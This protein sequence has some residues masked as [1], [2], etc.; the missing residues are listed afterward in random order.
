MNLIS[1]LSII[2]PIICI[3]VMTRKKLWPE[4]ILNSVLL[5]MFVYGGSSPT[6]QGVSKDREGL[7]TDNSDRPRR[8]INKRLQPN[9]AKFLWCFFGLESSYLVWGVLQEKIMTTRY[10][11]TATPFNLTNHQYLLSETSNINMEFVTHGVHSKN[12]LTVEFHDSQFLVFLNRITAFIVSIV[13]LVH[14]RPKKRRIFTHTDLDHGVSKPMAPLYEYIYSS[15][16][17]ILSS[18]CQYEAL[19]YVNFPTQV[20]SKSCKIIP[21][22]LMSSF[23]MKKRH[24]KVDYMNAFILSFGMFVF[25]LYQPANKNHEI[26][27]DQSHQGSSQQIKSNL[28]S[29]DSRH[30]ISELGSR[31]KE[32]PQFSGLIILTL[33]LAFDSFTSNWQQSLFSRYGVNEWQMMAATNFYS[34]LLTLTSLYQLG[35]LTPALKLLA[36]SRTLLVDCVT[37]S[38]MSSIGQL[39]VFYTIKSFGSVIFAVIM[40]LRQLL[41]ILMSC[42]IYK[43]PLSFGSVVGLMIVFG[44]IGVETYQKYRN[45]RL[46]V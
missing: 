16:S 3:I 29:I 30:L 45:S 14:N 6:L 26:I 18:W 22:M 20:I 39:F 44:V 13:A 33:Y 9:L 43:H 36:S 7:L 15:L 12:N 37:M 41:A 38:M 5:Q 31:A 27:G 8:P 46:N 40:T 34:I 21:V 42:L 25:L 10:P 2:L 11:I 28:A 1:Y 23:I 19:K 4:V 17:N 32:S 24:K 35:H